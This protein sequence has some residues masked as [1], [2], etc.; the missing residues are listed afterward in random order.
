MLTV[1]VSYFRTVPS[2][3]QEFCTNFPRKLGLLLKISRRREDSAQ[4]G[5]ASSGITFIPSFVEIGRLIGRQY[6]ATSKAH[7]LS[8]R[9]ENMVNMRSRIQLQHL[10]LDG[11]GAVSAD[12]SLISCLHKRTPV[13]CCGISHNFSLANPFLPTIHDHFI[14]L[15]VRLCR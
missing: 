8:L 2:N 10:N 9:N 12:I 3:V 7:L 1:L 4:V 15:D 11:E 13:Y 6:M 14:L 5:V